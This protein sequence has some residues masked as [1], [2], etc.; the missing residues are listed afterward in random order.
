[1]QTPSSSEPPYCPKRKFLFRQLLNDKFSCK[2]NIFLVCKP[3]FN[4]TCNFHGFDGSCNND[5]C[6][7]EQG[8]TGD[9][10]QFCVSSKD[11]NCLP[12]DKQIYEG[13][14]DYI[15]GQGVKC[16]CKSH[17]YNNEAKYI[18]HKLG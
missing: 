1:M 5:E 13:Y 18:L 17:T 14:V 4:T 16:S 3:S 6:S 2:V 9:L 15:T 11:E 12:L 7:C 8:Y 10:C